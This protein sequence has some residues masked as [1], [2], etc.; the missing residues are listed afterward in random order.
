VALRQTGLGI[1]LTGFPVVN[2]RSA[3]LARGL[4]NSNIELNPAAAGNALLVLVYMCTSLYEN[5]GSFYRQRFVRTLG[6]QGILNYG[7]HL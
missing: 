4:F 2:L 6:S 3:L 5:V 7:V 1:L